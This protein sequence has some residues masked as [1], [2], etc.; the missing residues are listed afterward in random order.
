MVCR[1]DCDNK[2]SRIYNMRP[3]RDRRK[4]RTLSGRENSEKGSRK[5]LL[6]QAL[7]LI[8]NLHA[9]SDVLSTESESRA[10]APSQTA[11]SGSTCWTACVLH[12]HEVE[13]RGLQWAW[14]VVVSQTTVIKPPS[15]FHPSSLVRLTQS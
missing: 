6:L 11:F 12:H 14:T 5:V 4:I 10:T 1:G 15:F 7:K 8:Y 2:L 3:S 13:G 9:A